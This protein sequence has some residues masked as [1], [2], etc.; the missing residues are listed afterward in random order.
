[1]SS[2]ARVL[3]RSRLFHRNFDR[4]L[5]VA[6][7]V[8]HLHGNGNA[9]TGK[10]V[11]HWEVSPTATPKA[12]MLVYQAIKHP[13]F[14]GLIGSR[15]SIV[16]RGNRYSVRARCGSPLSPLIK[17][18]PATQHGTFVER[19]LFRIRNSALPD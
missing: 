5:P 4:V 1:M 17:N 14:S 12:F 9:A 15:G 19:V 11:F 7:Q 10:P 16:C 13:Q 3:L 6:G 2:P 18:S 8:R